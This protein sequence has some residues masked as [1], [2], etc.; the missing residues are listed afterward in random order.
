MKTA[1]KTSA[2]LAANVIAAADAA[3]T[4]LDAEH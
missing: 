1:A 4:P 3:R 2:R